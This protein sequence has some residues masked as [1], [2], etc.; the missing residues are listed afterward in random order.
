MWNYSQSSGALLDAT[1]KCVA[2]GYSGHGDGLN[3]GDLQD[4]VDVGPIPRGLWSIAP[5]RDTATHGPYVLPL[6][7]HADTETFGRD[8]FLIHG[9]EVEHAGEHLASHGCIILP[10][11]A[12]EAIWNSNDHL[13][14]V[15][16]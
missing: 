11:D 3:D 12:R 5:P 16:A 2:T 1:G 6:T 9:D 8:G 14:K 13:L 4:V 7:P 15:V 10:H